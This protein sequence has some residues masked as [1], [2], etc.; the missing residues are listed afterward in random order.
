MFSVELFLLTH[1]LNLVPVY[2]V[3]RVRKRKKCIKDIF[4]PYMAGGENVP[5]ILVRDKEGKCFKKKPPIYNY[6]GG[7]E[8]LAGS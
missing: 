6:G 2:Y 5:S 4:L 7:D 1:S 3:Q 8:M